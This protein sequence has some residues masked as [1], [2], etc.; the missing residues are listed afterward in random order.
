METYHTRRLQFRSRLHGTGYARNE[1]F[2]Q[3]LQTR[4]AKGAQAGESYGIVRKVSAFPQNSAASARPR[5]AGTLYETWDL[6]DGISQTAMKS[7][8][9]PRV[10][11]IRVYDAGLRN[12]RSARAMHDR[13]APT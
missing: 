13:L 6:V 7:I 12:L 9:A 10:A 5:T 3:S 8:T 2:I 11:V 1:G 4:Y